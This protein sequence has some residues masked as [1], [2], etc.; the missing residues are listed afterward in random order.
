MGQCWP[1]K[2]TSS[3]SEKEYTVLQRAFKMNIIP[4]AAETWHLKGHMQKD[5]DMISG[6]HKLGSL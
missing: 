3:S 6:D 4:D 5:N 2:C 1:I